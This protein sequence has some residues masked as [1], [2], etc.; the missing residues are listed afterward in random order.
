MTCHSW[1]DAQFPPLPINVGVFKCSYTSSFAS[2]K[3]SAKLPVTL[4]LLAAKGF[5][6]AIARATSLSASPPPLAC[7]LLP[8]PR[9]EATCSVQRSL[10]LMSDSSKLRSKNPIKHTVEPSRSDGT[11]LF[12]LLRCKSIEDLLERALSYSYKSVTVR[13]RSAQLLRQ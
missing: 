3:G 6:V 9:T 8:I 2:S 10:H 5:G 13:R 11:H 7:A 12:V 1:H 4:F